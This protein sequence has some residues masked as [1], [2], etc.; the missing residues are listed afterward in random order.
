MIPNFPPRKSEKIIN[1]IY[2]KSSYGKNMMVFGNNFRYLWIGR[3][4][5]KKEINFNY[6]I[7]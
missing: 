6:L 1:I 2:P 7:S 5:H 4:D 3:R